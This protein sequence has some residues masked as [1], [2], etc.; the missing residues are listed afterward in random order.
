MFWPEFQHI[1]EQAVLQQEIDLTDPAGGTN[2]DVWGYQERYAEYK[3]MPSR[4]SSLFRSAATG[5]LDPWHLSEELSSPALDSTFI[6]SNTPMARVEA[7][8]SQPD[9]ILDCYFNLNHVRPMV[10]HGEPGLARF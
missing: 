5:T 9:F 6:V 4:I 1:G 8:P 10:L 2:D 7:I 3:F